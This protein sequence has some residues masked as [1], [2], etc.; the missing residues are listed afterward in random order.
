ML[1]RGQH[2]DDDVDARC[3][4]GR[5]FGG[6]GARFDDRVQGR[7]AQIEGVHAMARLQEI[8]RHRPAHI[9]DADETD[10]GHAFLLSLYASFNSFSPSGAK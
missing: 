3:R 1:A 6:L 10:C 5:G 9:A 4:L 2:G 7:C 8:A